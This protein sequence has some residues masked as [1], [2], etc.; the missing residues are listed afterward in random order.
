MSKTVDEITTEIQSDIDELTQK[1]EDYVKDGLK[2]HEII[3]FLFQAGSKLSEVVDSLQDVPG[4]QKKEVVMSVVRKVYEDRDPDIPWIPEP[5]ESKLEDFCLDK[6]L[7][8][9]IEF[10]VRR[11]NEDPASP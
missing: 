9:F 6:V 10:I 11:R 4:E 5:F 2:I 8:A 1:F 7:S 3:L